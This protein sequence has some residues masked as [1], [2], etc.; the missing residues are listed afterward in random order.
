MTHG[1]IADDAILQPVLETVLDAVIVMSA[2][3]KILAWNSV[4]ERVFGWAEVEAIGVPLADLIVPPRHRTAHNA[5][6]HRMAQGAEPR[7]MN[8]LIEI[9][10][11]R[12]DGSEIPVE[13][14]I[15]ATTLRTGQV[16]I[17]FLRDITR[18]LEVEQKLQ[19][20]AL[21]SHQMLEIAQMAA[22][23]DSFDDALRE[24]LAAICKVS[25]WPVG[26]AFSVPAGNASVLVSSKIWVEAKPGAANGLRE[27][28]ERCDFTTGVGLPGVILQTGE[29]HWIPETGASDNFPRKGLGFGGAFGFPLKGNGRTIAILE[30]FSESGAD[31]DP[32]LLLFAQALGEQIGRVFERKRAEERQGLL[33]HEL[34]HRVKNILAVVMAIS[35]QT[36]A[37]ASD[38]KQ[39]QETLT[40]R[41]LA[42]ASAQDLIVH[43][44]SKGTTLKD[45]VVAAVRG[46]GLEEDRFVI[47]GP[48]IG[49]SAENA[50]SVSLGIHELATN[51]LKYGAL[52]TSKGTVEIKWGRLESIYPSTFQFE[53]IEQG[54]PVVS[55]PQKK[56]FGTSLLER[57]LAGGLGGT[58]ELQYNPEG[59]SCKFR[60]PIPEI[61]PESAS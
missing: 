8:R 19:R 17:G 28:T 37:K 33:V 12:K 4:A 2:A 57:G 18:R 27:A 5:G 52:S 48:D 49:I 24:V 47:E 7:V 1:A 32:E 42:I 30:F 55:Q 15:T 20:Q 3:G 6:L 54:G 14:S 56:G 13:L 36:I 21:E 35:R 40:G 46:C 9:S 41:L 53:W 34:N 60:A 31:P 23:A 43:Q 29:P 16:F 61:A 10:A 26:H 11:I 25:G 50:V 22:E 44:R 59:F 58:L 39:A 51:A 38:L 45:I